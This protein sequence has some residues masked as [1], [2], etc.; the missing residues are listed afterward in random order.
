MAE[1][2]Y[3]QRLKETG[4]NDLCPCGSGMKYKKCHMGEDEGIAHKALTEP[5]IREEKSPEEVRAEEAEPQA[6][7][8]T[9]PQSKNRKSK[10]RAARPG[11]S[12]GV[13]QVKLPRK[14]S[15]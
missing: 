7:S 11:G 12:K 3:A 13:S 6:D 14:A 15:R 5:K 9:H 2:D 8:G 4:R 10:F 1:M